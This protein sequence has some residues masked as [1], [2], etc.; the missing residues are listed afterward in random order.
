[1]KIGFV[2]GAF[3]LLHAGH[4][5]MLAQCKNECDELIVAIQ[6]DPSIERKYKNKP[7][8]S[9]MERMIR[10]DSCRFV[11]H[12][13]PYEKDEEIETILKTK[14]VNIRFLGSDYLL[15]PEDIKFKDLVPIKYTQWFP[16]TSTKLRERIKK[17]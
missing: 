17:A 4:L 13:I 5:M 14:N 16:P 9:L 2:A 8:E 1:M 15:H 10:L 6:V 3:D 12:I 11:D 7:I